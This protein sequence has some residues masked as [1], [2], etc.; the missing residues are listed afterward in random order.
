MWLLPVE[1]KLYCNT[2]TNMGRTKLLPW[3]P[4]GGNSFKTMVTNR[5]DYIFCPFFFLDWSS[6]QF[7]LGVGTSAE[8]LEFC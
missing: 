5:R 3:R 8:L 2:T 7:N 1:E 6:P 4:I